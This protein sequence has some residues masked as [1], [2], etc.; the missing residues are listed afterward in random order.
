[1]KKMKKKV[2]PKEK[3]LEERRKARKLKRL[4][5]ELL[6]A[7]NSEDLQVELEQT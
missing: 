1:M 6:D 2:T 7:A 3:K 4:K 5:Q